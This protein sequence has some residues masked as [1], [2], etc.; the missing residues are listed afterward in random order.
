M[1]VRSPAG[2][3]RSGAGGPS[4]LPRVRRR[5]HGDGGRGGRGRRAPPRGGGLHRPRG[6]QAP[7]R[8][9]G[10]AQRARGAR[11]RSS[12]SRDSRCSSTPTAS[13]VWPEGVVGSISHCAGCCGVAVARAGASSSLGLDVERAEPLERGAARA[14]LHPAR[15][16][17][18]A[19]TAASRGLRLGQAHLLREGERLQVLL[20]A[21]RA[22]C[23]ASRTSRSS[24]SR[25]HA[26]R[27]RARLLRAE[28]AVVRGVRELR[29]ARSPGR[30]ELVFAGVTLE[31]SAALTPPPAAQQRFAPRA[32]R[33]PGVASRLLASSSAA[34][35][36]L[37]ERAD[38]R[39]AEQIRDRQRVGRSPR[40]AV[41]STCT[42]SSEWPPRSKKL[43][44]T[45]TCG[46]L[47]HLL[48]ELRDASP[49][50]RSAARRRRPRARPPRDPGR[51]A[52]CDRSCG[53][54]SAGRRRAAT[55]GA[56]T[57]NSGSRSRA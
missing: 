46:E 54:A 1:P 38:R 7:P 10:R 14:H 19:R 37:G 32:R 8:V 11:W 50:A 22:R 23:S 6:R 5:A 53:S 36:V 31:A 15:A 30:D 39:E 47:Q 18:R 2:D 34:R 56:G 20:P 40:A 28:R 27:F 33:D 51:A 52:P 49:R 43:S 12:G 16:R 41:A 25:E 45:P 26:A 13:R 21:G 3:E 17:A 57:M 29:G 4:A 42:T 44:S 55:T 48:P 24:S 35:E 9:R